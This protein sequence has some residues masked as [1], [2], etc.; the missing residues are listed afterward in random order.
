M[1]ISSLR[2]S[3]AAVAL[4]L[5][6]PYAGAADLLSVY[7]EAKKY[8]A[9]FAAAQSALR[10]GQE[11]SVQGKALWLPNVGFSASAEHEN[12][13][14]EPS[15][16]TS[17]GSTYGYQF[18]V[19]QPI[20][21]AEVS[22]GS[23]QLSEQAKL[24]EVQFKGAEQD[25]IL[26]VAQSYF[27]VL[28][29]QDRLEL[30]KAQKDATAQQLAQ[31]KK[32]FEVGVATITDTHEAQAR[33]DAIV[34]SEIAA[35]NDL[36]VKRNAFLQLT[37][38]PADGVSGVNSRMPTS[39][40]TPDDVNHWIAIAENS[41]LQIASKRGELAI[42]TAEI[43]KY[44]PS[45]EPSL[46]AVASYGENRFSGDLTATRGDSQKQANIGLQLSIPI[47]TGGS[48]SSKLREAIA[49]RDRAQYELEATRRTVAL[50]TKQAF[51]GVKAGAAQIKALEQALVSTQSSLDSTKLGREVGVR[52]TLD[53]LNA[54]QQFFSTRKDL[55]ESR[56]NYLLNRLKLS[57]ATGNL[58]ERTLEEINSNLIKN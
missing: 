21:N 32:S 52:T 38:V 37:G 1:R 12:G 23:D 20:Y 26:R 15:G 46:Q 34:A 24:A 29:A 2:I 39:N 48:K 51:L 41:S 9:T 53:V 25:L 33:F 10:A 35:D 42:S 5:F 18:K 14:S 4:A 49:N 47:F 17:S 58:S 11:K 22:V 19:T 56:Y 45:R 57:A 7:Q 28:L 8:D 27:D 13:R 54:Q 40:P 36:T 55:A 50:T 3:A 31:A 44:R 43:E 16:R 30:V 6:A